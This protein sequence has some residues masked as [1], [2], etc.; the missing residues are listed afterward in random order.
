MTKGPVASER[1]YEYFSE[2]ARQK[3]ECYAVATEARKLGIDPEPFVEIPQAED[4]ASRV[5]ELL[6]DY[7][8]E[9]VAEDIRRLISQNRNRE[10]VSLLVAKEVARRPADSV[11]MALDRAIRVGLAVLTEGIL[12]APL[13]GIADVKVKRND[14]GTEF[15][16][17]MLAGPI[18]AAGGT[19]QAMSVLIAD[20]VRRELNL[21][22]YQPTEQEIAR[23]EEEIALYRQQQ[24]LQYSPTSQE[25]DLI[26]RNCPIMINGEGTE[27]VEI[28]GYRD[29]PRIETNRVRGGAC[30]V[31]A[32]GLCQKASKIK[33][34][35]DTLK[36]DGWDFIDKYLKF[37]APPQ[38]DEDLDQPE[39]SVET[40]YP[41]DGYLTD[42]IAGRPIFGYPSRKGGFRL[43]YGRARTSGLAALAFSPATMYAMEEFMAI[44]TQMRIERPGKGCVVTPCDEIEG[45][46]VVLDNGDMIYCQTKKEVEKVRKRIVRIIDNGEVLVP[47]GEF[48]EN[49]HVLVP[50]GY[51]LEW[52]KQEIL[53]KGELPKDWQVPTYERAKEM[54]LELDIPL[55]PKYNL[56]WSDFDIEDLV[57]LRNR[58]MEQGSYNENN[59]SVPEEEDIKTLLE[60]LGALHRLRNGRIGVFKRYSN[61]ILECLNLESK[62]GN[63]IE[64]GDFEGNDALDAVSNALGIEIRSKGGTRIGMRMGRP[65]KA[66]QRKM[67]PT[68]HGLFPVGSGMDSNRDLITAVEKSKRSAG[69]VRGSNSDVHLQVGSRRCTSC[70]KVNWR[71]WCRECESHTVSEVIQRSNQFVNVGTMP[72]DLDAELTAACERMGEPKPKAIR[73][74]QTLRSRLK[75]P[76]ALEKA[77][78]RAKHDLAVNKDGTVRYDMTDI[79]LTHF[80]PGEIELTVEKAVSLGYTH[81]WNGEPLTDP[82]QICEL[83]VQDIVPPMECGDFMVKVAQFVDDELEKLYKLEPYYKVNDRSDLIGEIAFGLAPHTSGGILCRIIGYTSARGCFGHPFFHAAKRRNCDGDEDC[84]ILAMDALLNFSFSFLPSSRGGMMDAPLVLTTRLD[85]DEIDRE[86]HN[87]DCLREYPLELYHAAM[88]FTNTRGVE[89][90]M[91]LVADRIG[92]QAQYE[93]LGFTHDTLDIAEGPRFSAYITYETMAEKMDAQLSLGEKIRAV[94]VRDVATRII[95]RHFLPDMAGNLRSFSAQRFR[96]T[97]C[98]ERYRRIPISE[99]CT[100]CGTKVIMTVYRGSVMKYL[101]ISKEVSEKYDVNEYTKNRI[102]ILEMS[103]K[104]VFDNDKVRKCTLQDFF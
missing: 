33:R 22:H 6:K 21:G 24:H 17:L 60:N 101:E 83:K 46:T 77:I 67:A 51:C 44:G 3:D 81:D 59:I 88:K 62:S 48:C 56:F 26:V 38:D 27:Q 41:E 95:N 86:A 66:Y 40:V 99:K 65:E 104:S 84:I 19:A 5:E 47:F 42:I 61:V 100:K 75:V 91:D 74:S 93:G 13:E 90:I 36:I 10:L 72:V 7:H 50:P 92:T 79:P 94:D 43:R 76:E 97:K 57:F 16:D 2:L 35:V 23:F 28:S 15:V 102:A 96:C 31:I 55:H 78:L 34:H 68:A 39:E 4:L 20:V 71:S 12:V 25:I 30:L 52:H 64:K 70:G 8:V 85:P 32:E 87:V 49:N 1:M 54:S 82:N 63:I 103:M 11:E 53:A 29:L 58:L 98:G 69:N 14:D 45:P 73:C 37:H 9:G 18:R 89:N 80:R